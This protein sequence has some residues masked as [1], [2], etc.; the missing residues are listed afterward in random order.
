MLWGGK[1]K[2]KKQFPS[3]KINYAQT[4]HPG[5]ADA[6][7]QSRVSENEAVLSLWNSL[8]SIIATRIVKLPLQNPHLQIQ[9]LQICIVKACWGKR[10]IDENAITR[11][12]DQWLNC[13]GLWL[14]LV[15]TSSNQEF[16]IVTYSF[17]AKKTPFLSLPHT[18]TH[19]QSTGASC[20]I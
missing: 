20:I 1:C 5:F 10:E 15:T 14:P 7:H 19:T 18:D 13:P 6:T 8:L 4:Q 3:C 9:K 16:G 12:Y 2:T 11:T 17:L